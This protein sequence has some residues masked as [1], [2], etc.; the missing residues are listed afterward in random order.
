MLSQ[1]RWVAT[2]AAASTVV[3]TAPPRCAPS[4][5]AAMSP[6]V[7]S[8]LPKSTHGPLVT[9][10]AVSASRLPM[11]AGRRSREAYRVPSQFMRDADCREL[12]GQAGVGGR[13]FG[14]SSPT[15][16]DRKEA[17]PKPWINNSF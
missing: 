8:S 14:A 17:K 5:G 7:S 16:I 2:A 15:I 13:P 10:P 3:S 4:P 9:G 6:T 11:Q 1:G 12:I